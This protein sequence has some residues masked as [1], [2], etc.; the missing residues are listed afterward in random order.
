VAGALD[1]RWEVDAV[2]LV[3]GRMAADPDPE[4]ES[5]AAGLLEGRRHPRQDRRMTVHDV[6][7]ERPDGQ[8]LGD[9]RRGCQGRPRLENGIRPNATADEVIPAPD[10]GIACRIETAGAVEPPP[11]VHADR[12]QDDPDGEAIRAH[13]AT[14]VMCGCRS[15]AGN[16]QLAKFSWGDP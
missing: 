1:R 8:A 16:L 9:H 4:R 11:H 15:A 7:D 3:L 10:T 2:G 5:A 13:W 12:P 14:G 6:G